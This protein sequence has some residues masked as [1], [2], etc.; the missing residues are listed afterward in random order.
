[1]LLLTVKPVDPVQSRKRDILD[2]FPGAARRSL[3]CSDAT[4]LTPHGWKQLFMGDVEAERIRLL[5]SLLSETKSKVTLSRSERQSTIS[6]SA[7]AKRK[8]LGLGIPNHF[9]LFSHFRAFNKQ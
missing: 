2:A 6:L 3:C 8:L 4:K 1:M 7:F 5:A 9:N